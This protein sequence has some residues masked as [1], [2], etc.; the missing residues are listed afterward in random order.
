MRLEDG[1]AKNESNAAA[2]DNMQ[3]TEDVIEFRA[4]L[5]G[6]IH[7]LEHLSPTREIYLH[8]AK[9]LTEWRTER[10]LP[11][12]WKSPPLMLTATIDDGWGHGLDVIEKLAAAI[13]IQIQPLGLLQPSERII[14]ACRRFTP[15]FLGLTVLQF[16]SDDTVTDIVRNIPS[17]TLLIAGGAA[18]Q[19]DDDFAPRTGTPVVVKNG[20]AFLQFLMQWQE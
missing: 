8:A 6:C 11:G 7:K 2:I 10:N 16:D 1:D 17:S 14:A 9:D 15:R 20:T 19:Y 18:Y 12:L 5:V 3:H 4:K 13:G